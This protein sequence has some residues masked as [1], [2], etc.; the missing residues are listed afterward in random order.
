MCCHNLLQR[1]PQLRRCSLLLP[2]LFF[3]EIFLWVHNNRVSE[4]LCSSAGV[5][6][7]RCVC[8]CVCVVIWRTCVPLLLRRKSAFP[9][10]YMHTHARTLELVCVCLL[11]GS[12]WVL[13]LLLL[14]LLLLLLL[15]CFCFCGSFVILTARLSPAVVL[16][17]RLFLVS[18]MLPPNGA[19]PSLRLL[20]QHH[21]HCHCAGVRATSLR[22][23]FLI[24][25]T[26]LCTYIHFISSLAL[27]FKLTS[28]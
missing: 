7:C 27:S 15:L 14:V 24:L 8:V 13:K 26:Y 22:F 19:M 4:T 12:D 6:L 23:C 20:Y 2:C 3:F 1:L 17:S 28:T 18:K 16:V 21:C 10:T 5:N 25:F 9:H 11:A